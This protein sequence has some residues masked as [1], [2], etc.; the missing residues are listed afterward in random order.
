MGLLKVNRM[1]STFHLRDTMFDGGRVRHA[2]RT[3]HFSGQ[4]T[5]KAKKQ[6]GMGAACG[7]CSQNPK[8]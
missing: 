5:T 3:P 2:M 1:A 4:E 7:G 6:R 8:R